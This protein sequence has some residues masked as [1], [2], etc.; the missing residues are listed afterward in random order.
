MARVRARGETD[1]NL[2][3]GFI[4]PPRVS[5]GAVSHPLELPRGIAERMKVV[6]IE[7]WRTTIADEL[8]RE[9]RLVVTD[10]QITE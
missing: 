3:R 10:G 7:R 6:D 9:L 8:N 5:T 4:T 2:H 1:A